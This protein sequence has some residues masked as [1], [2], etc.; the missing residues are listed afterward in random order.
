[1]VACVLETPQLLE[2]SPWQQ[3][4]R[5]L[6]RVLRVHLRTKNGRDHLSLDDHWIWGRRELKGGSLESIEGLLQ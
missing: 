5:W 2:L 4:E 1:L 6:Q 3:L